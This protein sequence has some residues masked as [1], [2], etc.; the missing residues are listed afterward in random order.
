M[1]IV[2]TE[3]SLGWGGQEIRIL[4]EAAGMMRRGHAVTLLCPPQ[5]KIYAEAVLRGVPVTGLPMARKNIQGI[6]AIYSWL[7]K[8]P[9]DVVNTHSSTD[10][11]L[12]AIAC[13]ILKHPPPMIRTRH[14]SAAVPDNATTRWLYG[15]ATNH[16]VT[17]GEKLREQL[18]RDNG[19]S[20]HHVTSVPTGIDLDHFAPGDKMRARDAIG[21]ARDK[22]IIGIVATLRSWKGHRY[23][24]E[25]F[26]RLSDKNVQL[27]IVGDGPQREALQRLI[28][29]LGLDGR[30]IMAGN[31]RDVLPWMQAMDIF[32]LPSYA[33]EGVPQALVQAML[34]GLPVVTTSVGAIGEAVQHERT[35]L[36]VEARNVTQLTQAL[37]QLLHN[38][39]F[40]DELGR[41]ARTHAR[42]KFNLMA[43]LI[44]METLFVRAAGQHER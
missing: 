36:I 15:K 32:V 41:A 28:A 34:C 43:M 19:Y 10:S 27:L 25:A 24:M 22:T 17:T 2:H 37:Q 21:L 9:A 11:W 16:V 8:N 14:I 40:C 44:R 31:Q 12:T 38:A 18:I 26:A 5:A 1:N 3:S 7:A 42:E 39:R 13:L 4:T 20:P 23:L 30:V 6:Y 35:G 33:N 29:E